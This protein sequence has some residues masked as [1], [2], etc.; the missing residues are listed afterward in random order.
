MPSFSRQPPGVAEENC[1]VQILQEHKA[2]QKEWKGVNI[3]KQEYSANA[4][5]QEEAP[6]AEGGREKP[7]AHM[8]CV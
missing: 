5:F 3:T 1:L 4:P 8:M 7:P 2:E 6:F